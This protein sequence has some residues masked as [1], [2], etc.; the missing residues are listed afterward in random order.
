MKFGI[1]WPRGFREKMFANNGYIHVYSPGAGADN[2]QGSMFS[3]TVLFSQYCPL[4]QVFS[5]LN[6]FESLFPHSNVQVTQF[7][8]AIK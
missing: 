2:P 6:D 4:L 8:L 7:D 3:L 5:P 1:D